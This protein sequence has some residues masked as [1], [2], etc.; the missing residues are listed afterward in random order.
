MAIADVG[1]FSMLR[2]PNAV[3]SGTPKDSRMAIFATMLIALPFM[4]DAM[5]TQMARIVAR[6]VSG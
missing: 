3:A 6:I 2:T 1:I 5:A 4:A